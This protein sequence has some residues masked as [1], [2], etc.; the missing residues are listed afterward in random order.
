MTNLPETLKMPVRKKT[1]PEA[2]RITQHP[3]GEFLPLDQHR[4]KN[5]VM[6]S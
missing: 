5:R 3:S 2:G 1:L 6:N 4:R